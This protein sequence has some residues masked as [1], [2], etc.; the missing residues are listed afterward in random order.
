M[1]GREALEVRV[2][3]VLWGYLPS[4]FHGFYAPENIMDH[5][6]AA[7]CRRGGQD[8][9]AYGDEAR[10]PAVLRCRATEIAYDDWFPEDTLRPNLPDVEF[11]R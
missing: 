8:A 3:T 1:A 9:T 5:L 7:P 10:R 6:H 2:G 4:I 11:R